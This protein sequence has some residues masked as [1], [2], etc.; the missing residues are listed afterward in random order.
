M[1]SRRTFCL[2]WL[3]SALTFAFATP[4]ICM[5]GQNNTYPTNDI[6]IVGDDHIFSDGFESGDTGAWS[7]TEPP[8]PLRIA[9]QG[10]PGSILFN[11]GE[12][13]ELVADLLQ[14]RGHEAIFVNG[15]DLDTPAEINTFDVI[16]LGGPGSNLSTPDYDVFDDQVES[17][18]R[19]GGGLVAAGWTI[20][21]SHLD[22]APEIEA[23][24]PV[25]NDP[26]YVSTT[27]AVPVPGHAI[28]AG[29]GSFVASQYAVWGDGAKPGATVFLSD[30]EHD[31]G[32]AW[33]VDDG[34]TVYLGPMFFEALQ[35]YNN[36][37]LLDGSQPDAVE[38]MLRAIEWAGGHL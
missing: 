16:V 15:E 38:I 29:L 32:E 5:A 37:D 28:S 10:E 21:S 36:E 18:V 22:N 17:Y 12:V 34:R 24:L 7:A 30:G 35:S 8:E 1:N 31:L 4:N 11:T 3:V 20:S 9:L 14:A 19:G 33:S 27:V 23:M 2:L 25:I 13:F 6:E 26:G